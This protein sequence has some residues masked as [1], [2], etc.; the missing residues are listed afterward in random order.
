MILIGNISFGVY[1]MNANQVTNNKSDLNKTAKD[2]K[3]YDGSN[4]HNSSSKKKKTDIN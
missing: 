1:K 2:S 4:D 3:A